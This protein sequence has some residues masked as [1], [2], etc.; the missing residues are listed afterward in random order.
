MAS[1]PGRPTKPPLTPR[2]I[3]QRQASKLGLNAVAWLL[4][5]PAGIFTFVAEPADE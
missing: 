5:V 3:A 1:G 4:F 2:E